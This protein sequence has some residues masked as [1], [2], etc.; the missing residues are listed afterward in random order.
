M[1]SKEG[2][3]EKGR[4]VKGNIPWTK[5]KKINLSCKIGMKYKKH[6]DNPASFKK[7]Q[8]PWNV[9][10]PCSDETKQKLKVKSK[11]K[12]Y[13]PET[14]FKKNHATWNK[15]SKVRVGKNRIITIDGERFYESHLV[16]FKHF[17][18]RIPKGYVLHHIDFNVDNNNIKN[19]ALMS[20]S[21][22][23]KLHQNL[24]RNKW[25]KN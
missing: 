6:K 25:K 7:G 13:S 2:R 17:G 11:G 5:G 15:G 21:E 12:H 3:D 23:A 1:I 9:G 22:H 16:W 8:I 20:R 24:W 4:F 10:I 14:E 18:H 19:L